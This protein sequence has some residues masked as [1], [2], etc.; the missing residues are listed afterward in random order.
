MDIFYLT[1]DFWEGQNRRWIPYKSCGIYARHVS[2]N[3]VKFT[4][5]P[6]AMNWP[7]RGSNPNPLGKSRE[8]SSI[9]KILLLK[10]LNLWLT[11][12]KG[13]KPVN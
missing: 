11:A 1:A 6:Q 3:W 4:E 2:Y 10:K 12:P 8:I 7:D 5:N 9:W 13:A